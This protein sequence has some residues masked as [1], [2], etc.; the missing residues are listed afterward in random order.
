MEK[1]KAGIKNKF[2]KEIIT[3][4]IN[5]G[6]T[7]RLLREERQLLSVEL[8]KRAG[9]LDPKTLTA[10]EKGRIRNPSIQTL[11]AIARGLGVTVS[12]IF[13]Q[14]ELG[15]EKFF[16]RSSQKGVF[17]LQL[18]TGIELVSFTPFVRGLFCGKFIVGGK[19]TLDHKQIRFD[20]AVFAMTLVGNFRVRVEQ[21]EMEMHEG[22]NLYFSGSFEFAFHNPA[23]RHSVLLVATTP[24][25]LGSDSFYQRR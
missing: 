25:F 6:R 20:G 9:G 12:T 19:K 10:V 14:A 5:I 18:G 22:D 17:Q 2:E 21:R 1:N 24:S 15:S 8:C 16:L 3:P 7:V 23:Y 4:S 11:E 13:R